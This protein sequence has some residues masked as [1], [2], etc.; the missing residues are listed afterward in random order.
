MPDEIM[1][2]L[3]G[4]TEFIES[5]SVAADLEAREREAQAQVS[6]EEEIQITRTLEQEVRKAC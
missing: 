5:F 1:K 4:F 3:V 2:C 6:K